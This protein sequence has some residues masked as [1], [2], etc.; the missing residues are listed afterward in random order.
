MFNRYSTTTLGNTIIAG[1]TTKTIYHNSGP[2]GPDVSYSNGV[3]SLGNNL[4]GDTNNSTQS[5]SAWVSSDLTGTFKNPLNPMLTP[6]G[7]Y[8]GPTQTMALLPG[9]PAIDAGNNALIPSGVTTDQRGLPRIVNGNVDIGAFE[10]SGFTIAVTSGSGQTARRVRPAGRDGHRHQP[11]RAG[12]G[13]PG[14]L[15]PA[16]ERGVGGS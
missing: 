9:S 4:I 7:N 11:D 1:N 15:H 12:G 2:N 13:G 3:I 16:D 10:S 6:L 5:S 8:G 14:H